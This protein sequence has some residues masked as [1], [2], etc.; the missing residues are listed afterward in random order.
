VQ[1]S[2]AVCLVTA[3]PFER[4]PDVGC[5]EIEARQPGELLVA[6]QVWISLLRK[7]SVIA[8]VPFLEKRLLG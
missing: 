3:G 4:G 2:L 8:R 7:G 1:V 5:F 6:V